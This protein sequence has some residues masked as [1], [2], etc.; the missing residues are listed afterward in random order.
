MSFRCSHILIWVRNLQ[1]AVEDYRR[2][3]FQV[4]FATNP[5]T[6]SHA[7]IWFPSGPIIELLTSP[8]F[9]RFLKWPIDLWAG[10]GSGDRMTAW[11]SG[12][13]GFCDLAVV[14]EKTSLTGTLDTLRKQG[15]STGKVIHW[16]RKKPGGQAVS[17]QFV[18]PCN[19]ALPFLVT[20]DTPN[21]TPAECTHLNGATS[22]SR[23]HFGTSPHDR[24]HVT[25]LLAS[26]P[27]IS[28]SETKKTG[29]VQIDIA[30]IERPLDSAFLHGAVIS[31][32]HSSGA[33]HLTM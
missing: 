3:G 22:I 10:R 19:P 11:S 8:S 12:G 33:K 18:Y 31:P 30:G 16:Q 13:E 24:N 25:Q 20:P 27:L 9:S 6:A 4:H 1:A 32:A 23:I 21:Q 14:T 26:D 7:H 15:L 2:L 5:A 17:F 28:L 29:V